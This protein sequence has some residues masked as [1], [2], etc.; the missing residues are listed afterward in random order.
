MT[1]TKHAP[2][3]VTQEEH[4]PLYEQVKAW[5]NEWLM[6]NEGPHWGDEIAWQ[7]A[8][9]IA[10]KLDRTTPAPSQ[11]SELA[12]YPPDDFYLR[13]ISLSETD[14]V[15]KLWQALR[16]APCTRIEALEEAANYLDGYAGGHYMAKSCAEA[17]RQLKD[18]D[19]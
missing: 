2:E 6:S 3:P 17:I 7:S 8:R 13:H 11:H 14:L 4:L 12:D 16:Q 5:E 15:I 1:D 18:Q 10:L 9:A 19:K